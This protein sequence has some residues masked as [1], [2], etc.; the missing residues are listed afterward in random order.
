LLQPPEIIDYSVSALSVSAE[1]VWMGVTRR[2]EGVRFGSHLL[3]FDRPAKE[4]RSIPFGDYVSDIA[5][6]GGRVVIAGS[7]SLGIVDGERIDRYFID[8]QNRVLA[9][10][11]H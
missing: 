6:V 4:T 11:P 9:F 10:D 1:D 8:S 3:R 7:L 2:S 5:R